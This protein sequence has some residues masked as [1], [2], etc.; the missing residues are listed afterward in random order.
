[1]CRKCSGKNIF[2]PYR[3][4]VVVLPHITKRPVGLGQTGHDG[5]YRAAAVIAFRRVELL[6]RLVRVR[7]EGSDALSSAHQLTMLSPH[8]LIISKS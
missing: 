3:H 6:W 2:F 7:G 5:C 4:I 1:M 8:H